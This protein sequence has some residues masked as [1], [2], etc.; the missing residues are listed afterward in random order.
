VGGWV[1]Y[2][3]VVKIYLR[4]IYAYMLYCCYD[5][6]ICRRGGAF[7]IHTYMHICI[8]VYMYVYMYICMYVFIY[9]YIY[10]YIYT[11][12]YIYVCVCVCRRGG[13]LCRE[14]AHRGCQGKL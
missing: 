5:V 3:A 2:I 10:I 8:Y 1:Y 9:I 13:G 7:V 14:R 12:I 4:Y 6:K 11:Y